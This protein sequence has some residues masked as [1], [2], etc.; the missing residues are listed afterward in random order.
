MLIRSPIVVVLAHVD[1]GKT[2]ILDSVRGTGV[3]KKE[4]GGITQ[5]IGASYVSREDI[6][7]LSKTVS[8][9]MRFDLKI[10]GLL[11]VDTPGHEAFTNLRER[12]GSIAD[13]AIL[14]VDIQQGFQPQTIESIKILKEYKTPFVIAVNKIDLLTGWKSYATT[15]FLES[16]EK[17][18]QHLRE[19]LDEK[20]YEI[21]GKISEYGF[22]SERFDRITDFS[23]QIA[24]IPISAKT[25]E[26][27]SE[28]LVLISGLS[29]K[30]LENALR[31]EVS[32]PAKGNIM[33]VKEE[34]GL[35]TTVDVII[36]EGILRKGN[37]IMFLSSDG[38]KTTNVRGLLEPNLQGGEKFTYLDE[39]A[40]AAGV[41]IF[42][43][44]LDN[45]LP[46][47]PIKVVQD[48]EKDKQEIEQQFKHVLVENADLGIVLKADSLGSVEAILML[49]K[50]ENI[51]VKQVGVGKIT[52]KDVIAAKAVS[53]ENKY[54][55]TVFGFNVPM[56]DE[57]KEEGEASSIPIIWS[58]IIYKLVDL[59]KEWLAEEK[60]KEKK[61][62]V[63]KFPWPGKIKALPG[64][65]F[66]VS[67][68][69]IFGVQVL[70]GRVKKGYRMMNAQGE[71]V[72][73]IREIQH[74]KKSVDEAT[75]NMQLAISC[76][77]IHYGKNLSEG[78]NLYVFISEE[79]LV[80]WEKQMNLLSDEEKQ[81]LQET[82]AKVKKYF[83]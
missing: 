56:L 80:K 71:I 74:E 57:A 48:F 25:K 42:A 73:E 8:A 16:L 58:N 5:M 43:P 63:L 82:K 67:K 30:F 44:D 34:K 62:M 61:E 76:D 20:L 78:D 54:L 27:L 24:I 13:I 66:R 10:P 37:E 50:E 69:A 3:A 45:A 6:D 83:V 75:K 33:E 19:R 70:A 49:L 14:V 17:Q 60:E 77:G 31:I 51:P 55:G 4:A 7:A 2:T 1:H 47:S 72:G 15:S 35:G 81:L 21:I 79:E 39:V 68:P 41:K 53:N 64:F 9:K 38:I 11:F 32:G 28:L 12:G 29:Q 23:K 52:R 59:Y 40:A 26:G 36:Y 46:G 18:P 22:D 65:C